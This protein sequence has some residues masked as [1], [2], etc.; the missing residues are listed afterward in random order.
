[1]LKKIQ[2]FRGVNSIFPEELGID[3]KFYFREFISTTTD[4]KIA[5]NFAKE[6][7][8]MEIIIKNNGTNNHPNYC[9]NI[10]NFSYYKFEKEILI[11]SMC[12]FK[13]NKREL[14][15]GLEV[16]HLTCEGFLLDK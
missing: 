6:K 8:L 16:I 14:I 5:I 7:T 4:K 12:Y 11:S 13:V 1:M 9:F 2:Q 10:E 3:T 15:D